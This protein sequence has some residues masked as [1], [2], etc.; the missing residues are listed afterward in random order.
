MTTTELTE[1]EK[2]LDSLQSAWNAEVLAYLSNVSDEQFTKDLSYKVAAQYVREQVQSIG[3]EQIAEL[4]KWIRQAM[5]EWGACQLLHGSEV[6]EKR[7]WRKSG[8]VC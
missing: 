7:Q 2:E 3:T 8:I 4:H 5:V 6:L 1:F